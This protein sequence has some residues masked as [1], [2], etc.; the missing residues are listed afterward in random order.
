MGRTWLALLLSLAALT[1]LAMQ[2]DSPWSRLWIL[3]PVSVAAALLVTWRFG[4]GGL[5]IP[6]ALA[7]LAVRVWSPWMWCVPATALTGALMGAREEGGGPTYGA[8]AL[9]LVPVLV[10]AAAL[11]FAAPYPT[12]VAHVDRELKAGDAQLVELARAVG[13]SG[14]RLA[15]FERTVADN[16]RVRSTALPRVLPLVLFV[17][18]ALLVSAG[19]ALA[20]RVARL[21]RWPPLS[22]A[23]LRDWRLPDVALWTM[24]VGLALVLAPWP[25]AASTAWTLL[26]ASLLGFCVQGIAVVESSLL[27][28]GVP[29]ALV[30]LTLLFVFAVAMP[31]F[32]L[33][34]LV[35][36]VSDAWLD[37]RRLEPV[38]PDGE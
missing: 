1:L 24:L 21:L 14:P 18:L 31:L 34:V 36:G 6:A 22:R 2:S 5:A 4:L 9:L 11:P 15:E 26:L 38:A 16:A 28:R 19:R 37:Y 20:A 10:F 17:W 8:R 35:V 13:S 23:R 12:L 33:T 25:V 27:T 30:L 29:P 3:V 32:L 7:A